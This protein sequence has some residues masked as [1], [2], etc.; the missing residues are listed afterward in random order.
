MPPTT[1]RASGVGLITPKNTLE[2]ATDTVKA[3]RGTVKDI[4]DAKKLLVKQ[5]WTEK[6]EPISLETLA[7]IL[8]AH[9]L[10]T[11]VTAE[12]ASVMT[13]VA[14]IIMT[15]LQDGIA[16]GVASSVTELLK[17]SI[18][19][20]TVDVQK[21]LELHASKLAESAQAQ[22]TIAQDMQKTQEEMAE[23]ARQAATQVRTYSQAVTTHPAPP[24][25]PA[26]PIT[27]SQIQIQNRER[28]KKRQV[29][30]DFKKTEE[31]QLEDMDEKTITRKAVD[32]IH[33]VY[34][35]AAGP[36]PL[37]VKLKSGTLLRNGGLLLELNSDEAASWLK[38]DEIIASFL[39][40]VGSGAS[41]KN[42]TYQVIVQFVPVSFDPAAEENIRTYEEHNNIAAGS[43]AKAE[44]IKPIKD[45]K[46][47]QKVATLRVYHRDAESAN[48]ILKQGAYIFNKRVVPKRPH[49]EPIRCLRCHKFGHERRDCKYA[50]A[51]CGKCSFL[52]ETEDCSASPN[53]YK[54]I[55]CL[56]PHPSYDR[57]CPAFWEKCQQMDQQ[58]PEN[59]LAYYPTEE[60][61]TWV[62]L[63][64][65]ATAQATPPI[66]IAPP[67]QPQ[68]HPILRQTQLSG[69]NNTPLG[70]PRNANAQASAPPDQ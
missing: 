5:G 47:N 2:E 46:K 24:V 45:R 22:A 65:A 31:L 56:G 28:I 44:W 18:A 11:K 12:T 21:N 8:L 42:R 29:L 13:A 15:N 60:Q 50:N 1:T 30:V 14:F 51:Y 19:S 57:E 49:R 43:V 25:H 67:R 39:E 23:S 35:A 48:A 10:N 68:P 59:G 66:P 41:V 64:H 37:E 40:N 16:Q 33:T 3:T 70:P 17:H 55:N 53:A 26:P 27:H 38:S 32:A 69:T 6:G 34:A 9:S 20:M 36:K 7:R 54:C 58:C 4:N 63:E 52:H 61:W 62:T